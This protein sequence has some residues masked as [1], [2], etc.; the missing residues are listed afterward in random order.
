MEKSGKCYSNQV[1]KVNVHNDIMYPSYD[2][3]KMTP[4]LCALLLKTY[5]PSL[6][7]RKTSHKFQSRGILQYIC[8]VLLQTVKI[9]Q[10]KESLKNCHS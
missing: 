5:I 4:Y 9:T 1:V 8:P 2:V 6:T 10:N 7:I 3:M